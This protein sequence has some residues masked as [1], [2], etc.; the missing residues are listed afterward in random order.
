MVDRKNNLTNEVHLSGLYDDYVDW[1]TAEGYIS[2]VVRSDKHD[3]VA[4]ITDKGIEKSEKMWDVMQELMT[5]KN[6]I[7]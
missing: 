6:F 7:E 3:G 4:T 5:F 1:L 2:N